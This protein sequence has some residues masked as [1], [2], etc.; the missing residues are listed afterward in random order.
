[1]KTLKPMALSVLHGPYER[2]GRTHLVVAAAAMTSLDGDVLEHEQTM[3]KT[4][5][6]IPGFAGSLDELRP[7]VKP[8]VLA[9]GWAFAP[10]GRKVPARSAKIEVGAMSKE[11][12]VVGDRV[13]KGGVASEPVPFDKMPISWD[14]AFGG[15]GYGL[16]PVGRGF[17]P[18]KP[19]AGEPVHPLPNVELPKKL[20]ASPRDRPPPAGFAPI[21]P[22]WPRR[23]GK[24][25]TYDKRWLETRFP[26]FPDDFD[27][28]YFNIAPED[29]WLDAPLEGGERVV[30]EHMHP[31]KDRIEGHLPR[32][33]PRCFVSREGDLLREMSLRLDTVWLVPHAE[34]VVLIYRGFTEVRDDEATDVLD[35]LVAL[36]RPGQAKGLAH[37]REVREKR[38]DRDKGA[39]YALRDKDL[40]P[41]GMAAGKAAGNVD[42]EKHLAREGLVERATRNRARAELERTREEMRAMGVDPDEHLPADVP[43]VDEKVPELDGLAEFIETTE[44][45]AKAAIEDE[46]KKRKGLLDEL[47]RLCVENDLDF[48][49]LVAD[50]KKDQGG[51]PKFNAKAEMERLHDLAMLSA[52]SGV[53]IPDVAQ[54]ADEDLER[55]LVEAEKALK[56]TYRKHVHYLPR[57][58]EMP[59]EHAARTRCEVEDLL[60]SGASLADR[61][62]TGAD[63]SG[64]DFSGRDLS[65]S[66]LESA[67]LDGARFVGAN[68]TEVVLARAS[69]VGADLSQAKLR[70]ANLGEAILRGARVSGGVDASESVFVRADLTDAD[71]RGIL[72]HKADITEAKLGGA[73][74]GGARASEL[75]ILR[76]DFRG[77]KLRGARIERS[78]L[79]ELDVS[80]V[81]FREVALP[82]TVFL[83]VIA[84][85]AN[86][87]GADLENLRVVGVDRGSSLVG[88]T[89]RRTNLRGAFLRGARLAKAD[90]TDA[91]LDEIDFSKCDLTGARLD[92]ARMRQARL[93]KANLT[94]ASVDRADLMEALLGGAILRGARFE[95]ASLFRADTVGAVGDDRTSFRG[96]NVNFVRKL[97]RQHG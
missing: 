59:E 37:Y 95:Q 79:L 26:D 90:F 22:S 93:M 15:E 24:L 19:E 76:S 44:K 51:P 13:W 54:L 38:L 30:I 50:A 1:M 70:G 7:K 20:C 32:F 49:R 81:D 18:T 82:G 46:E 63:L 14:R 72:L 88:A 52:N 17:A 97:P 71:L 55:K 45:Q 31:S 33:L 43:D 58:N 77:V 48:D 40:I 8:E 2:K 47:K 57:A 56:E 67:R 68:L 91:I 11:L 39:I 4:L 84:D 29:Q 94:N 83:D 73:D 53:A 25:G 64:L 41:E 35:V 6:E 85:G 34:R 74:L 42:L 92:G 21:D 5:L 36:E 61:D 86:F 69:L 87:D 9:L 60:A 65:R 75:T 10:P 16:N 66:F 3:W 12:W 80:G 23:T 78:N 28:S 89:F 96:A 62:F 27:P